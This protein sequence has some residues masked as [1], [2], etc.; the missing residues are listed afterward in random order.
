[1]LS[2]F[3]LIPSCEVDSF[4]LAYWLNLNCKMSKKNQHDDVFN[5]LNGGIN[6]KTIDFLKQ[7]VNADLGGDISPFNKENMQSDLLKTKFKSKTVKFL[8]DAR[9]FLFDSHDQLVKTGQRVDGTN[10]NLPDST[11]MDPP[12]TMTELANFVP[13]WKGFNDNFELQAGK[14]RATRFIG[15]KTGEILTTFDG[16]QIIKA[17]DYSMLLSQKDGYMLLKYNDEAGQVLIELNSGNLTLFSDVT[18]TAAAQKYMR[19]MAVG[20]FN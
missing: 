2:T 4:R 1:M 7:V 5:E 16:N 9:D 8:Y 6:V 19:E 20:E 10:D 17:K 11:P 13:R 14:G 12:S 18:K 3:V 15:K